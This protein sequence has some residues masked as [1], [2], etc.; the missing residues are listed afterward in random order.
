VDK[1]VGIKSEKMGEEQEELEKIL[2]E[3]TSVEKRVE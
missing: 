2:N 1:R 3:G